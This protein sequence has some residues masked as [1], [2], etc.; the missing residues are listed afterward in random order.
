MIRRSETA[1]EIDRGDAGTIVITIRHAGDAAGQA[2]G[3]RAAAAA[4]QERPWPT[5]LLSWSLFVSTDGSAVMAYEQW[6]DDASLDA[7]LSSAHPD[8]SGIPGTEPS[9]PVRYRLRRSTVLASGKAAEVGCVVTPVFDV[10]GPERQQRFIDEVFAMTENE[11][12]KSGAISAH[13][14]VS[15]DGTRV[16]NYAEWQDEQS[17]IDA[18]TSADPRNVRGRLTG[19]IPGVRPCGYRRW[20]LH[21]SLLAAGNADGR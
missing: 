15:T 14:H 12:V 10:D 16:F 8:A 3:A 18:V 19:E 13:F 4:R 2:A 5:G 6:S 17:H 21:T 20:K 7:A 11:P 1:P 9:T